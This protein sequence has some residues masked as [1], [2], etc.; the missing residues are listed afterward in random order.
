MKYPRRIWHIFSA[1][2][3]LLLGIVLSV[4]AQDN[5]LVSAEVCRLTLESLWANATSA[6]INKPSGYLCNAGAPPAAEPAGPVSNALS[7]SGALVE[8]AAVDALH[9]P[10]IVTESSSAGVAYLRA[11]APLAY[12]A[13]LLGDVTLR[14]VTPPDFPAWT[15]FVV[16]TAS[17]LPS[18][19]AA[20]LS[21]LVLQSALGTSSRIVVNGASLLLN[22]VVVVRTDAGNTQFIALSG[23]SSVLT[24]N[25]EQPLLPGEQVNV[26]HTPENVATTSGPPSVPAPFD[27]AVLQNL[28]VALLDRPLVV[29]QPGYVNTQGAVNMR[30]EPSVYAGIIVQ[31]PPSESLSVLG[32]SSDGLWYHVRRST[33][34]SG[35]ML[36]EL[37]S[38]NV[39]AVA[40]VYD[41]TP[42]PPQR[43]G[44]LGTR[45]RVLAPAG[46]NLR[47]GPD[48]VFPSL[49]TVNDGTLVS[50]IARSPYS[51]WVKVD[52]GGAVGWLALITLETQAYI[53][54]LPV[55]FDA[56]PLPTPTTPPGSFGNA[57]P[58][59]DLPD[60]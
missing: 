22:G 57:F 20:P 32:R 51:P 46:V 38:Q 52:V 28:P 29:P 25:Q 43:Y 1:T 37:L 30:S 15:S 6:C 4:G 40:A 50:L 27:P 49:G 7:A 54:A 13:L 59:P 44:D 47:Q 18:C 17:T 31:V 11:A 56:P 19:A 42:M 41:S 2:L 10:P 45:G 26:P 55:D 16:E 3:V 24:F 58:D 53:D 33:G 14:D 36:A 48:V 8:V 5:V 39:G 23:A 9:T 60:N 21:V 34:E 12:T 35:W